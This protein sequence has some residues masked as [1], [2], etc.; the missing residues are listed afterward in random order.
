M[1]AKSKPKKWRKKKS[2]EKQKSEAS[3]EG[4]SVGCEPNQ[5]CQNFSSDVSA[6]KGKPAGV[7]SPKLSR[8]RPKADGENLLR[9]AVRW[10]IPYTVGGKRARRFL[11]VKWRRN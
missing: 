8:I 5:S 4:E 2:E 1:K 6:F 11:R 3:L 9:A 10:T 7:V